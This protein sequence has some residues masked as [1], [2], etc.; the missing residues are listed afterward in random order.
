[1]LHFVVEYSDKGHQQSCIKF[2]GE[3]IKHFITNNKVYSVPTKL[4][5]IVPPI[6]FSLNNEGE[7]ELRGYLN[8]NRLFTL[9]LFIEKIGYK[10]NTKLKKDNYVSDLINGVSSVPYKINL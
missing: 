8:N 9:E 4:P 3:A 5:M 7:I 6:K 1:M 2:T 10:E